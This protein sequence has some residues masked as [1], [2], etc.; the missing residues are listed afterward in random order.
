LN[1][2]EGDPVQL[3]REV[4]GRWTREDGRGLG[5]EVGGREDEVRRTREDGRKED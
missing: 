5:T 1:T 3:G 4:G 2:L